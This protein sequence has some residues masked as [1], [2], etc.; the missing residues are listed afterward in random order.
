MAQEY[1]TFCGGI[2]G[3]AVCNR[4]PSPEIVRLQTAPTIT[5]FPCAGFSIGGMAQTIVE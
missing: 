1:P 5:A 3:S 2:N 4:M